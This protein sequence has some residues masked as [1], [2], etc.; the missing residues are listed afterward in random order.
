MGNRYFTF[1][2][3]RTRGGFGSIAQE[4]LNNALKHAGASRIEVVLDLRPPRARLAVRDDGAGFENLFDAD[5]D[6]GRTPFRTV[7][8]PRERTEAATRS[9]KPTPALRTPRLAVENAL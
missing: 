3:S 7:G 6:T 4:A 8:P 5:Y 1:A 9:P 2:K